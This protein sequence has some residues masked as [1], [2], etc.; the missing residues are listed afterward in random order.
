M[1]AVQVRE[2]TFKHMRVSITSESICVMRTNYVSGDNVDSPVLSLN[3]VLCESTFV[4]S[5]SGGTSHTLPGTTV[6]ANFVSYWYKSPVLMI[7]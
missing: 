3:N 6:V 7:D 5:V 2:K 1:N 4:V